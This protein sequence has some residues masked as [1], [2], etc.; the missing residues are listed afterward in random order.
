VA[1]NVSTSTC[2]NTAAR[3]RRFLS[4][5]P[6]SSLI[7]WVNRGVI[8]HLGCKAENG[9][10]RYSLADALKLAVMG[11][12]CSRTPLLVPTEAAQAAELVALAA[13]EGTATHVIRAW[14]E[15]GKL[16]FQAV[17]LRGPAFNTPPR[18]EDPAAYEPLRRA[19]LIVPAQALFVDTMMRTRY[20]PLL[21]NKDVDLEVADVWSVR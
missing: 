4:R 12:V 21:R 5:V 15:T 20:V 13:I 6:I 14:T 7:N 3:Q 8:T 10:W 16:L 1:T 9:Y 19:C 2:I 17:N 11:D 18:N